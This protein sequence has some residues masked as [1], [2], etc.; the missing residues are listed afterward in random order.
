V[1]ALGLPLAGHDR[2]MSPNDVGRSEIGLPAPSS[3]PSDPPR[4]EWLS[5]GRFIKSSTSP[6]RR[7]LLFGA[8]RRCPAESYRCSGLRHE[9]CSG[10]DA[11]RSNSLSG[12]PRRK[13]VCAK[14]SRMSAKLASRE[15]VRSRAL[16]S[17]STGACKSNIRTGAAQEKSMP[18]RDRVL[19]ED[20]A[21]YENA[22]AVHRAHRRCSKA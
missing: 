4:D 2:F 18:A 9:R 7:E 22:H 8:T 14:V 20:A 1:P 3:T 11:T 16:T 19:M 13:V 6:R 21:S 10:Q 17:P 5:T 12:K 15:Y